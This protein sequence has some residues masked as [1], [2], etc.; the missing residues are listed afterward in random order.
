MTI[1]ELRQAVENRLNGT[2]FNVS[3]ISNAGGYDKN[4]L[5]KIVR[6][7]WE[8]GDY[9]FHYEV[10]KSNRKD[11]FELRM[12]CHFNPYKPLKKDTHGNEERKRLIE[13]LKQIAKG[14]AG[15]MPQIRIESKFNDDSLWGA[16]WELSNDI[17]YEQ[18]ICIIYDTWKNVDKIVQ[19]Q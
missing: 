18:I 13:I 7:G 12:D 15:V 19:N 11:I 6:E 17:C 1:N 9:E 3:H 14:T 2:G 10:Q 8:N 5:F 4:D 16:K